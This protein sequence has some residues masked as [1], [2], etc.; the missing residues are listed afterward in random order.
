MTKSDCVH[1]CIVMGL[2]VQHCHV[3]NQM[4]LSWVFST[5]PQMPASCCAS[6]ASHN[7]PIEW[8]WNKHGTKVSWSCNDLRVQHQVSVRLHLE[9]VF[10]VLSSNWDGVYWWHYRG[11]RPHRSWGCSWHSTVDLANT[12]DAI[13]CCNLS[14]LKPV[15]NLMSKLHFPRGNLFVGKMVCEFTTKSRVWS[16]LLID[17]IS[18]DGFDDF[19]GELVISSSLDMGP[20]SWLLPGSP[21]LLL[22]AYCLLLESCLLPASYLLP[23]PCTSLALFLSPVSTLTPL[24]STSLLVYPFAT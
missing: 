18:Y 6:A 14:S 19:S 1:D 23:S 3:Q 24:S 8:L 5:S 21:M 13:C 12:T 22:P 11:T 7:L 17:Y 4:L 16:R 9:T 20:V 10:L 2:G 15:F